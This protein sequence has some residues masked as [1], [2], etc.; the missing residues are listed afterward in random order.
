MKYRKTIFFWGILFFTMTSCNSDDSDDSED[1]NSQCS[2]DTET[3]IL[4]IW[5]MYEFESTQYLTE[6]GELIKKLTGSEYNYTIEFQNSPK[7][8]ISNGSYKITDNSN[9]SFFLVNSNSTQ[10]E[11]YHKGEWNTDSTNSRIMNTRLYDND[12]LEDEATDLTTEI[13]YLTEDE[14]VLLIFLEHINSDGKEVKDFI[15]ISY[16]R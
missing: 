1:S 12:P 8:I 15:V 16:S 2:T 5:N 9:A 6:T 11:G 7:Q 3:C 10:Q 14:M 13:L 4:G